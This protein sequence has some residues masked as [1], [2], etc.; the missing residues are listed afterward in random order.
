MSKH[1]RISFIKSGAR[2]VGCFL[3]LVFHD[4]GIGFLLIGLAEILGIM[5]EVD[6]K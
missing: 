3:A 6:E 2:I 4:Y 5:E 1:K